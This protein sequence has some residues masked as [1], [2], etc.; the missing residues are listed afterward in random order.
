[1]NIDSPT[2]VRSSESQGPGDYELLWELRQYYSFCEQ[3]RAI[4]CRS[5]L[6]QQPYH[7]NQDTVICELPTGLICLDS[8]ATNGLC[9]DYEISVEC[10]CGQGRWRVWGPLLEDEMEGCDLEAR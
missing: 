4:R 5:T 3:P 6:T 10:D 1:M 9:D 7:R 2:D 8:A